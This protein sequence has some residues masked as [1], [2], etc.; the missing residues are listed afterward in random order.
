MARSASS[1]RAEFQNGRVIGFVHDLA[2]TAIVPLR[3]QTRFLAPNRHPLRR[4]K[5]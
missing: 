2:T 5:L 1:E 4:K 3:D